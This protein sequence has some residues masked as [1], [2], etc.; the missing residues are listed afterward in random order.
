MTARLV[1]DETMR[2][3]RDPR[4][5]GVWQRLG[6]EDYWRQSGHQPDFRR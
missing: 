4:M 3:L 5:A 2:M 1:A 6:L